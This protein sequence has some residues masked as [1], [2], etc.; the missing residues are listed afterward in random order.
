VRLLL[1]DHHRCQRHWQWDAESPAANSYRELVAALAVLRDERPAQHDFLLNA[2]RARPARRSFFYFGDEFSQYECRGL[3]VGFPAIRQQG[4]D[5]LLSWLAHQLSHPINLPPWHP[6]EEPDDSWLWHDEPHEAEETSSAD[7]YEE[8]GSDAS[9]GRRASRG[10]AGEDAGPR[11]RNSELGVSDPRAL[12]GDSPGGFQGPGARGFFGH[13]TEASPVAKAKLERLLEQRCGA[14][15]DD[16]R[17][18]IRRGRPA[19]AD[20]RAR[21]AVASALSQ[22]RDE[23]RVRVALLA[24]ILQCD[25]ATIWRLRKRS[26]Q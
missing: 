14:P 12:L 26:R 23:R 3:L 18:V 19:K 13:A 9:V 4:I 5:R 20:T 1:T 21:A 22:L 15:I 24:E 8:D 17:R 6:G 11:R 2:W 16:I 7:P 10:S 25:P